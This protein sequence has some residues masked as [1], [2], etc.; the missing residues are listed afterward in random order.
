MGAALPQLNRCSLSRHNRAGRIPAPKA[1]PPAR[2]SEPHG[3]RPASP[4]PSANGGG[5]HAAAEPALPA[6][7]AAAARRDAALRAVGCSPAWAALGLRDFFAVGVPPAT[8]AP[9]RRRWRR[10]VDLYLGGPS[11]AGAD[12]PAARAALAALAGA[13]P[14]AHDGPRVALLD[15]MAGLC[16]PD[17]QAPTDWPGFHC[18]LEK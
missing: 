4:A 2:R 8:D 15:V 17:G 1:R 14:A 13:C 3:R 18:L 5:A 16:R 6:H 9:Y 12:W 10:A 7:D 11:G